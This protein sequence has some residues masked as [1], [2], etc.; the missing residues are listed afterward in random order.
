MKIGDKVRIT[1]S[2]G[3]PIYR[4][5]LGIGT[6]YRITPQRVVVDWGAVGSCRLRAHKP[7][8]LE[9]VENEDAKTAE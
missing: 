1:P 5:H 3:R 2:A 8:N 6:V 9:L 4:D 7:E